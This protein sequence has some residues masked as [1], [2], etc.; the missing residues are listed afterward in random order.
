MKNLKTLGA[1]TVSAIILSIGYAL[2]V[3]ERGQDAKVDNDGEQSIRHIV[4][5]DRGEFTLRDEDQTIEANWRSDF[6]LSNDGN[7]IA[8]I[9]RSLEIEI[10]TDDEARRAVFEHDRDGVRKAYYLDGEKQPDGA[11]ANKAISDLLLEF[12]RASGLKSD[13]RVAALLKKGGAAAVLE[14]LNLLKGDRALSRYSI[15]LTEQADLTSEQL[16]TLS[17]LLKTIESDHD[18]RLALGAILENETIT[19]ET[20]PKLINAANNIES[21]HDLRLL[22]EAFAERP[23]NNEALNLAIDL[24]ERIEGDHDLRV[25]A[26]A[27]LDSPTLATAQTA[28]L[29]RTAANEIESDHDMRLILME[30]APVFFKE[31]ALT[32]AWLDGFATLESGHDQRLALQ[33]VAENMNAKDKAADPA[34]LAAYR[35][36]AAQINSD[37]DRRL[38]LQAIG[39]QD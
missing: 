11:D 34:L 8:A 18:L 35:K 20:T 23:L 36:A 29:L 24:Y 33:A 39:D 2:A 10:E 17:S 16:T 3:K 4:N 26:Q 21:D 6:K 32:D 5:G 37:H 28:R 31:Q 30:T 12:L 9:D 13:D 38:A 15:A 19:A 1:I 14:E 27:L 7:D 25:A 22:V